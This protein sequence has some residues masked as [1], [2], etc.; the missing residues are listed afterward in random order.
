MIFKNI[1]TVEYRGK[2]GFFERALDGLFS[3]DVFAFA[4]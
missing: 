4:V 1:F 3:S 2:A